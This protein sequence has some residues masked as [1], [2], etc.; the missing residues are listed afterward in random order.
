MTKR[1]RERPP[2]W[3]RMESFTFECAGLSGEDARQIAFAI[4][5]EWSRAEMSAADDNTSKP[6]GTEAEK[7]SEKMI[8]RGEQGR[9]RA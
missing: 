5:G 2:N 1:H 8:E 3:R 4:L 7:H 6:S 9:S